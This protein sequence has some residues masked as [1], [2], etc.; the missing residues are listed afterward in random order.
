MARRF[1]LLAVTAG[2]VLLV[3]SAVAQAVVRTGTSGNDRLAGTGDND[4]I[5]GRGGDDTTIGKSGND[6]YYYANGWGRDTV[7][8]SRGTDT[9]DFSAVTGGITGSLCPLSTDGSGSITGGEPGGSVRFYAPIEGIR[10]SQGNDTLFACG[11]KNTASGGGSQGPGPGP[12]LGGVLMDFDGMPI[13]PVPGSDDVYLG[14]KQGMAVVGD[15]GGSADVLNLG[16]FSSA[17]VDILSEDLDGDGTSGSLV[18][19]Y[20][21]GGSLVGQ[22]LLANQFEEDEF[23][24]MNGFPFA[25]DGRIEKIKFKN[26]TVT[27]TPEIVEP[28]SARQGAPIAQRFTEDL[29]GEDLLP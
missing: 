22:M 11:G 26:G 12:V 19:L 6:T 8:D 1:L 25:F 28:A 7:I 29:P 5:T 20:G 15:G 4:R 18:V 14:S 17:N 13:S 10:G 16:G 9:L 2:A 23:S 21:S 27:V 24:H 3:C